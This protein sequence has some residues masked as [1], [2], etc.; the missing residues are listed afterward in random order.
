MTRL[1][2]FVCCFS[3]IPREHQGSR[4]SHCADGSGDVVHGQVNSGNKEL[5]KVTSFGDCSPTCLT[6]CHID[7]I[8][9]LVTSQQQAS[10]RLIHYLVNKQ[11]CRHTQR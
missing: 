10:H 7:G 9:V 1:V 5:V 6:V 3:H 2:T 11:G 4:R 8:Y